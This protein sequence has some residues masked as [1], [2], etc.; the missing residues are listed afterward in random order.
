MINITREPEQ[1]D[2]PQAATVSTGCELLDDTYQRLDARA[3]SL[4]EVAEETGLSRHWVAK[5]AQRV[6]D[7]PGVKKVEAINKYLRRTR[8]VRK[9]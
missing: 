2:E 8:K 4:R 5:F 7:D 3:V 1:N 9:P 6:F